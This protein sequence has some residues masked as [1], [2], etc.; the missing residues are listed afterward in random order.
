MIYFD[1]SYLARLAVGDPRMGKRC[2]LWPKLTGSP[3]PFTAEPR[4]LQPFMEI[5]GR[6]RLA[7][8]LR[9]IIETI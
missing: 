4:R 9:R 2:M 8:C 5:A 3:A 1:T 7:A 6:G